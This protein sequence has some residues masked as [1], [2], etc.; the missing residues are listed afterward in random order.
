MARIDG[1]Y[2]KKENRDAKYRELK[3]QGV[4]V[5]RYTSRNQLL[6]PMYVQDWSYELSASDRGFGNGIYKTHFPVLYHLI[7]IAGDGYWPSTVNRRS[8]M[9][10]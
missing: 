10:K 1:I 5:R 4:R 3:S 7:E 8:G 6:H 9:S 2:M